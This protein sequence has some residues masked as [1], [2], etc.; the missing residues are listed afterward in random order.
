VTE[1]K[2]PGPTPLEILKEREWANKDARGEVYLGNVLAIRYTG[3]SLEIP[4]SAHPYV[5]E[6]TDVLKTPL[7]SNYR[8]VLTGWDRGSEEEARLGLKRAE[9]LKQTLVHKYYME[10]D[11]IST[12]TGE[13]VDSPPS[14]DKAWGRGKEQS[15]EIHI[16]GNVSKA[17]RFVNPEED[18]Q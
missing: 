3:E 6:L 4:E 13:Q 12:R 2:D 16:Y 5:L 8:L 1:V 14:S 9:R 10:G 15:I 17:V 18:S 7:R 11:R